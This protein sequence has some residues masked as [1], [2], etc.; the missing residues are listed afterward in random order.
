MRVKVNATS[1][2]ALLLISGSQVSA[3]PN[4]MPGFVQGKPICTV[5]DGGG[6]DLLTGGLGKTGLQSLVP[7]GFASA[8]SPTVAELRKRAIYTN[9]RAVL[10]PTPGGGYGVLYGPNIDLGGNDTLGEG[11]IAG[12]ECLAFADDGSGK[13]N[14]TMMVQI[15]ASF[16][17]EN[18]CIVTGPSSGS[19]GVYGAIGTSGEWGLKRGC[20]V[21]YTDAGKGNGTHDL[22]NDTVSL[23]DGLRAP[24]S[25]ARKD[26]N[27]TARVN[28]A[29]LKDFNARTPN[30]FAF[31]HAHSERNPEKDWGRDVLESIEFAFWLLNQR[32]GERNKRGEVVRDTITPR[33]TIVIASSISNGGGASLKAAESDFRRLIDGVV[34]TEPN[35]QPLP[36]PW[37]RV[38]RGGKAVSAHSKPLYDYFTV[39]NLFQ[40]CAAQAVSNKDS[41][42]L[43]FI[44]AARA[45]NRCAALKAAGLLTSNSLAEQA[46]EALKALNDYGW[47]AESNL[48]HASHYA[49]ASPAIAVT[50]SNAHGRFSVLDN[51]CGASFGATDTLG[52]P[53]AAAPATVAQIFATG[54]GIPPVSGIN[55]INNDSVGGPKLDGAS[56]S[57][58]ELQDLNLPGALC[59]R[60]LA[61]G[62]DPST[63]SPLTG[64]EA[65]KA[66]R[67]RE[68]IAEVRATGWLNRKPTVI[69]HGRAD[70]LVPVNHT[71]RP[72][73]ALNRLVE[74][75]RSRLF[76]YEIT[77]GQH[78]DTFI[79]AETLLPGP[80]P[81]VVKLLPGFDTRF[82]PLHVYFIQALNLMYDHLKRGTP[83]PP[84]QVVRTEP[85]EPGEIP[86]SALSI[87]AR[88]VPP[89]LQ[90]PAAGNVIE[91]SRGAINV[92][93]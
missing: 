13:K 44:A 22:Q 63:G 78:F 52:D 37:L 64:E 80:P 18:A 48:L 5:Y 77:N 3:R 75:D 71:S 65:R 55:I 51:L 20:A 35:I 38:E 15:P 12:E 74:G 91:V 76:Y 41:P 61:N 87:T 6:D 72:Y 10:D 83:L 16:D 19:R 33:N 54:N 9:Y 43:V 84:S 30:R 36:L 92:P 70:A 45:A 88:N 82:V 68:G 14:V 1:A 47:E 11:K 66:R 49:F 23:I 39:A 42:G 90:S 27:F 32:H 62:I 53:D 29:K 81:V 8:T 7:P 57:P 60:R 85:R 26:S 89:I 67:V 21:A 25:A 46:D 59:F 31:K 69:V 73:V 4:D 93:E 50:Y 24:A 79:G 2:A 40:P 34:V 58:S 17:P 56:V 28:P 86:G